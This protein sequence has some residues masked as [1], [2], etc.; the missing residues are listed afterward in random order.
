MFML[1][2]FDFMSLFPFSTA[3]SC[4]A[5]YYF[6]LGDL[7]CRMCR[8]GTFSLGGGLLFNT[9]DELP[10]GFYTQVESFRSSFSSFARY[11]S[12]VNCSK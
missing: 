11:G 8:P 6:D 2:F 10:E 4:E 12:E 7:T 3:I 5:G 1:Q 9:W